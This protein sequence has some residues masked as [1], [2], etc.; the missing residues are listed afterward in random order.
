[1]QLHVGLADVVRGC[2]SALDLC[3]G[4]VGRPRQRGKK[5][6]DRLPRRLNGRRIPFEHQ[7]LTP[8]D[9]AHTECIA[10]HAE[11][12]IPVANQGA[13]PVHIADLKRL[14]NEIPL[15]GHSN[16]Q[17]EDCSVGARGRDDCNPPN[18]R[19]RCA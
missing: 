10:Q 1:M 16:P 17:R 15:S 6:S 18:R 9:G 8:H 12:T 4:Q 3:G 13:D 19:S 7:R 5:L 2:D 14:G 11:M